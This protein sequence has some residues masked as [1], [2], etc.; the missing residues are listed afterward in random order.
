MTT[1]TEAD[2]EKARHLV[3][4]AW[5][6]PETS[7][8]LR[9][10]IEAVQERFF[11]SNR[12]LAISQEHAKKAEMESITLVSERDRLRELARRAEH[13]LSCRDGWAQSNVNEWIADYKKELGK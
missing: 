2:L 10:A 3:A 1:P 6:T 8:P 7:S 13:L 11:A 12:A 5:C 9:E 4:Q